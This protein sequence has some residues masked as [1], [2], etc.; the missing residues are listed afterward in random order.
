[1][2]E[3]APQKT[4]RVLDR[5]RRLMAEGVHFQQQGEF[6]EAERRYMAVLADAPDHTDAL[7]FLGLLKHQRDG[8]AESLDLMKKSLETG[9]PNAGYLVNFGKVLQAY[10]RFDESIQYFRKA[11]AISPSFT[12]ALNRLG[13]SQE[14]LNMPFKAR[15]SYR[16]A[17]EIDP[18]L[19]ES[20]MNFARG[21]RNTG[22]FAEAADICER[23]LRANPEDLQFLYL[24]VLCLLDAGR[25]EEALEEMHSAL[26][27]D[28]LSAQLHY[29]MGLVM[30]ELGRFDDAK[31]HYAKALTIDP[32]YYAVYYSLSAIQA[33]AA[34]VPEIA[35]LE[36]RLQQSP[37][38]TPEAAVSA[39]FSLGKMLE[40]QGEYDRAFGHFDL[41][42]K[43]M[44][45]L[46]PYSTAAQSAY[47]D[48]LLKSL[49]ER[50]LA[51]GVKAGLETETPVFIVGMIRS[52]TSLVEQVLAGH[53][54]VAGGGELPF[55]HQS[56]SKYVDTLTAGGDKIAALS[57]ENLRAM[58]EHYLAKIEALH[59]GARRVTD[60]LPGNF[61]LLPLIH[62]LFPKA[63][64]IHCRRDPL[65]TCV[66]CYLTHFDT[67]HHY[68]YDQTEIGEYYRLYRRLMDRYTDIIGPGSML[69]IDYEDLVGDI[70]GGA[71]RMLEF[72]GLEW[73]PA[74]LDFGKTQRMVKTASMYQVRQPAHSS[75]IGRWRK[76]ASH[77]APLRKALGTQI[78]RAHV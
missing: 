18:S 6:A 16:K 68:A 34:G 31:E 69:T 59:P 57:D 19:S 8:S 9:L 74:C 30:A 67:G 28:P 12:E 40:D 36:Q 11:L 64:I 29:S 45:R 55:L 27:A 42:N 15:D 50:F 32:Q 21:L 77:I 75:S 14:L 53:P 72:C 56:L 4:N 43:I 2:S 66:S 7:H 52:G 71:R 62:T 22:D 25:I 35:A 20:A 76:Y 39:E 47:I 58:G 23:A 26:K 44:R 17:Y 65:D 61:M 48:S 54:E 70:E 73:N 63:R 3:P 10:G 1:M 13:Q 41:G 46:Q 5:T 49:D 60:K 78:G 33:Q 37:P 51:R 24:E 38:R